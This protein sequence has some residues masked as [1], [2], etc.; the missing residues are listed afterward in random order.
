MTKVRDP[1]PQALTQPGTHRTE[2]ECY[3]EINQVLPLTAPGTVYRDLNQPAG[4]GLI[5]RVRRLVAAAM[6]EGNLT[7]Q[8]PV[9]CPSCGKMTDLSLPCLQQLLSLDVPGRLLAAD[10]QIGVIC[11]ACLEQDK[12]AQHAE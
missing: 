10:V 3:L 11:P 5:H 9:F 1:I 4:S 7:P 8:D 12:G 2:E 6:F